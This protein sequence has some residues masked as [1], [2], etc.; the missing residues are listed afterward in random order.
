MPPARRP[1][2]RAA[3]SL[4]VAFFLLPGCGGGGQETGGGSLTK[5]E[6]ISQG[7][8][9][10]KRAREDFLAAE[11]PAPTSPERA[12][13]LQRALIRTSEEEVSR[14]RA[15]AAPAEVEPALDR[16]LRARERGIALLKRGLEAAEREDLSSYAAAQRRVA[17]GQLDRLNL[18]R[19]VGFVDCSRPGGAS[20]GG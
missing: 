5:A 9:I 6:V 20:S 3:A 8:A 1:L 2:A 7:D 13:A 12:A 16:Y 4:L 17:S 10:C 19:Q 11:P 18:A 15:L 14:I